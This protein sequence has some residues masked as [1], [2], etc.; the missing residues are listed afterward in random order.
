MLLP[1]LFTRASGVLSNRHHCIPGIIVDGVMLP[2]PLVGGK[3]LLAR[4]DDRILSTRGG[5][6]REGMF[7]TS[8]GSGGHKTFKIFNK[9]LIQEVN[10]SEGGLGDSV[11]RLNT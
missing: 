1:S 7:P 3:S 5:T 6:V 4:K 2:L 11:L 9:T 10:I 8:P